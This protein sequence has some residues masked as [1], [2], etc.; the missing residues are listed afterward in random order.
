MF[1]PFLD[2]QRREMNFLSQLMP[3]NNKLKPLNTFQVSRF[4]YACYMLVAINF[5]DGRDKW[6]AA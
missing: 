3:I 2:K 5:Y 1:S 6:G 4:I